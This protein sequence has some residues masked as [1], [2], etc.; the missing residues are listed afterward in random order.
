MVNWS[1][2]MIDGSGYLSRASRTSWDYQTAIAPDAAACKNAGSMSGVL[3][4]TIVHL[5]RLLNVTGSL[6]CRKH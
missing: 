3:L 5:Q 1:S 6:P 2:G 4:E